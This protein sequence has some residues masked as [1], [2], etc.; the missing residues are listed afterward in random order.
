MQHAAIG[1][2]LRRLELRALRVEFHDDVSVISALRDREGGLPGADH[3]PPAR[4]RGRTATHL[5]SDFALGES[6][7][8]LR[9]L[10]RH[11]ELEVLGPRRR[12]EE[13]ERDGGGGQKKTFHFL[14]PIGLAGKK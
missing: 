1:L 8:E 4:A 6:G 3:R 10:N 2:A 13:N 12:R 9:K 5:A 14:P 11:R 7:V